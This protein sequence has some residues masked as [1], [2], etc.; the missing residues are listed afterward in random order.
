MRSKR[1]E[2]F[3][4]EFEQPIEAT[5]RII[6]ING[7]EKSSKPADATIKDLSPHGMKLFTNLNF[8]LDYVD[9][10]KV[11]VHFSLNENCPLFVSGL[12]V[13]QKKELQ[14]FSYGIQIEATE[15]RE[16][17]IIEELKKYSKQKVYIKEKQ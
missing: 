6:E 17:R 1:S 5:L 14:G 10:I 2:Y 13:W 3:R 8:Q 15:E 4:F 11:E 16:K 12:F 7:A 9:S